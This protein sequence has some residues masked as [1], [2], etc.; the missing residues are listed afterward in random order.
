M[1][2][3]NRTLEVFSLSA[4]DLFASAMGAFIIIS[5]ILFPYYQKRIKAEEALQ[6]LELNLSLARVE[7][8]NAQRRATQAMQKAANTKADPIKL[9]I[10]KQK[11]QTAKAQLEELKQEVA[12]L[13][14]QAQRRVPFALLGL[15][16][17]SN[18]FLLLV[19]MSGSMKQYKDL[20]IKALS[21]IIAPMDSAT[22]V[23]IL[24]F[25]SKEDLTRPMQ[26]L[27][28]GEDAGKSETRSCRRAA[29]ASS[30]SSA[31]VYPHK[32][33]LTYWPGTTHTLLM[34][35]NNKASIIE[36]IQNIPKGFGIG[37]PTYPALMEALK[38]DVESIILLSDGAPDTHPDSI[39][40]L[41][42]ALN[43]G[44][45]VIHTVAIGNY[46]N[47]EVLVNFLK[48]LAIKNKGNFVGIAR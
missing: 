28:W 33:D 45:K 4:L 39:V 5:L 3:P 23:G 17:K 34:N 13:E 21:K 27:E 44:K 9:E 48:D 14:K 11:E 7:S 22:R 40:R 32:L 43:M 1:R 25:T 26:C 29:P 37:T 10:E 41:I 47:D 31:N 19:D 18:S 15:P 16:S 38:Y 36:Y 12:A 42:T 20:I 24:G 8:D 35:K 2:R 46:A 6:Q 30:S